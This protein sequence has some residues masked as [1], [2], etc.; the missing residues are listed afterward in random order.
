MRTE[1]E[2]R[3]TRPPARRHLEPQK[4][5]QA[6]RTLPWSLRREQGP[7]P[8]GSQHPCPAWISDS[9]LDLGEFLLFSVTRV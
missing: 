1:V 9:G 3:G 4:L 5:E 7:A 8:S 2:M 6:G